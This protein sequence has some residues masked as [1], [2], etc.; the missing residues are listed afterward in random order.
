MCLKYS[1]D[2]DVF[3]VTIY[4][5]SDEVHTGRLISD[6]EGTLNPID[7]PSKPQAPFKMAFP[8]STLSFLKLMLGIASGGRRYHFHFIITAF[9]MAA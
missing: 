8:S 5:W 7:G 2:T 4:I 1:F 3:T 9:I 6:L